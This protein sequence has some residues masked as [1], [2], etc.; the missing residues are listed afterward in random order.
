VLCRNS[1]GDAIFAVIDTPEMAASFALAI[2]RALSKEF[3]VAAGLPEEGGMR[4]ALPYGP[5][6]EDYDSV[7]L[8]RTFYGTE[9]TLAA[10]I[11][12]K[13][14]VG[15]IYVTQPFA[16]IIDPEA[17]R[18]FRLEYVGAIELAKQFGSRLIYRLSDRRPA[19]MP[20]FESQGH[21]T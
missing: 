4:I 12:P 10:R 3:L 21:N 13:V 15:G 16:A 5:V 9:I 1:W 7:R 2:Q 19:E 20:Q 8:A 18:Q 6:Y 17:A 14:P 11:E